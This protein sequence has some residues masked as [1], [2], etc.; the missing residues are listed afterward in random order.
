MSSGTA[1]AQR[2]G[3]F[4]LSAADADG[5]IT[6]ATTAGSVINLG[7]IASLPAIATIRVFDGSAAI[8]A[9]ISAPM[10]V[11]TSTTVNGRGGFQKM[12]AGVL[13]LSGSNTYNGPTIVAEGGLLVTGTNFNAMVTEVRGGAWLGGSGV[14]TSVE[15][16]AGG[17]VAPGLLSAIGTLATTG[18]A[19]NGYFLW[20][21]S[22]TSA[23][24]MAFQLSGSS[25]ASDLID[26]GTDN[27][28][29]GSGS[30]FRFDFLGSSGKVGETYTLLSFG[31]TT[32]TDVNDFSYEN[33]GG[34]NT[35]TFALENNALTFTVVPEP[36][37]IALLGSA[38][39]AL[40]AG[41]LR[42]RRRG[43]GS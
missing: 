36:G 33:L 43:A 10:I 27:L 19:G 15:L 17:T 1:N 11:T 9:N 13:Q 32:F 6:L 41:W 22:T 8:D 23:A 25:N 26:L 28:I 3:E 30:T 40:C 24:Q 37:T 42:R 18:N 2:N 12:G 38:G 35:G 31:T 21:G 5:T 4:L 29:K 34:T 14:I 20:N 39:I 16:Q 7:S